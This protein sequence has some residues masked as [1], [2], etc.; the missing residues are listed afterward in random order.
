VTLQVFT[1]GRLSPSDPLARMLGAKDLKPEQSRTASLGLT[2]RNDAG[3]SGSVD[4]YDIKVTDRFSQSAS[5]QIPAGVANP[6]GYTSVSYFTN[7]FDTTT[8]GIDL[9]GSY[10][11]DLGAGRLNLTVGWNYNK[12]DVD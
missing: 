1:S 8:R 2:W 5:F 3:F 11:T 6:M 12:T 4:L 7:D 10:A 9:V